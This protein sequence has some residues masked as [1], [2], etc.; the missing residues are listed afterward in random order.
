[1]S[2]SQKRLRLLGTGTVFL[3]VA[4]LA[5]LA[6]CASQTTGQTQSTA[7]PAATATPT[8][9][10]GPVITTPI[11][12][13]TMFSTATGWGSVQRNGIAYTVD[14]GHIWYNVTPPGVTPLA[15]CTIALYPM[16]ATD[17]WSWLTAAPAPLMA[18]PI[19]TCTGSSSTTL[20]YT[21]DAGSQWTA[22]TM[23]TVLVSQLDFT[24]SLHG[25]LAASPAGT[26]VGPTPL[27]LWRTTDGGA[28]WAK[29][30][31]YPVYGTTTGI[32]FANATTGFVAQASGDPLPYFLSVTHDGGSTWSGVS[33]P[34]PP[35]YSQPVGT[36]VEPPVFTGASAGVLEVSYG[37]TVNKPLTLTVYRTTDTGTS[38][39]VGPSLS[40]SVG[41]YSFM[42]SV[43]SSGEVFVAPTENELHQVTFYQLP[44]GATSWTKI[45]TESSSEALLGGIIQLD[46]V[47][48]TT[49]WAV[50]HGGLSL[51][52]TTNGGVTWT[53]LH[54]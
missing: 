46:F 29:A 47:N 31:S 5:V 39:Q 18:N 49:G 44:A 22:Y 15:Q 3:L 38:W 21:T 52:G 26:V 8:H 1:M 25:W 42:S 4:A 7:T 32:S 41:G 45:N 43:L 48:P 14:G 6:G 17:A 19:S 33:V 53:L 13:I 2:T 51:L 34:T 23:P 24:D 16:S 50:T 37:S 36:T 27:A 54:A 11:V 20:W 10:A 40:G 9:P 12:G 28:T 30:V 35:G